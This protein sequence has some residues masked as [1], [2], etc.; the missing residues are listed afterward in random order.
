MNAHSKVRGSREALDRVPDLGIGC[1]K[2][3]AGDRL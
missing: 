2:R 1:S 3:E